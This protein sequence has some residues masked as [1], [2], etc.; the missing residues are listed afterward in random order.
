[1]DHSTDN[2]TLK[3]VRDIVAFSIS[4]AKEVRII[5]LYQ[6]GVNSNSGHSLLLSGFELFG[7]I[8]ERSK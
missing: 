4:E 8:L 6:T 7:E 2:A 1:L 3:G 5:R